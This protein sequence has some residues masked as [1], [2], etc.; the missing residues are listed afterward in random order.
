MW[1]GGASH[2]CAMRIALVHLVR[3]LRRSPASAAAAIVTLALTLGAGA[4]IFAV[5]DAVL[6]TPPPFDEPDRL[7]TG[8]ETP[9]DAP[10]EAPRAIGYTTLEAWRDRARSLATIEAFDPTNLTLTGLGPAERMRATDVTPGLLALLGASPIM[11][12]GFGPDDMGRPVVI[13]SAAFWNGKL[14]GD[15]HAIGREIVLG[16]ERHTI[17]GVLPERFFFALDES[18]IWRPLP[19]TPAQAARAGLRVRAVA[20]LAPNV[21]PQSLA[22][23]LDEVSRASTPP[24]RAAVTRMAFAIAGRSA[25]PL[26]LLAGAAALAILI[27]FT[28]LAGLLIVR[29]IDRARELAV[30]SALGARRSE[31]ARQLVL[32]AGAIVTAGTVAGVL[33][34]FWLTPEVERLALQELGAIA[35]RE[36]AVSWRVIGG[37]S[38]LAAACACVCGLLTAIIAS[39]RDVAN[40]LRRGI[41]AAPRERWLR[42]AFVTAVVSFAFVLLVSVSLVGRSLMTVLAINPGFEPA[43]L[44]T[45]AVALPSARYPTVDHLVAFYSALDSAVSERLGPRAV[46]IINELPLTNDR[47]RGLVSA[48]RTTG[49][50]EA[51]I[52]VA[53]TTYFDVMHIA[54]VAGRT[55]DQRDDTSAPAR[56]VISASLAARLFPRESPIGRS[57]VLDARPQTAEIVGVVGDVKHRSLDEP[58]LPTLY[59][60]MWQFPSRGS[61]LVLRATRSDR[62][63]IAVVREEVRQL[64]G[65]LPVYGVNSMSNAVARSPGVPARRVLT[66][67]FLGF[68]VL[69]VMLGA[70]GLFGVV[71]HEV[72][73]RRAEL[74]LRIALG[75]NPSRILTSTLGQGMSIVASALIVGSVLSFWA[76]RSLA[77]VTNTSGSFDLVS[78]GAASGVL[79][80]AG[81]LAIFP[82]ARRA[83]RTDPLT[84]LRGD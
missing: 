9:R 17:V 69:S 20:R 60:S 76:S 61:Q 49:T 65:D 6:L 27:A 10:T 40:I 36:V 68:A 2:V 23:A 47:G 24:A 52:R 46:G 45:A 53:S 72:A 41:T 7:V 11:G 22:I 32:E 66:A 4:A 14:H 82:A 13:V 29:S 59:L 83:A 56:V 44:V 75:A 25:R 74:A 51:V 34:A 16:G 63:A 78:T 58:E 81:L 42:R 15:P 1:A 26:G 57:I 80:L 37:V 50:R 19:M 28:N 39:R 18:D 43:G 71:A 31:I 35:S 12:R 67:A 54:V 21:S 38:M 79:L 5:V 30:R 55:F 48:G 33:L 77:S 70:I 8:G 64:D 84:V 73:A 62:D 3:V